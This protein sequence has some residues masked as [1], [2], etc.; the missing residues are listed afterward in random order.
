MLTV[1]LVVFAAFSGLTAH[2]FVWP[3]LP[4]VPQRADAIVQLG[5]PG[6]RRLV[7]MDLYRQGRAPV[8]AI[9]VPEDEARWGWCDRGSVHGVPVVCF[10]SDPFTTRGEARA[11]AELAG[12]YEWHSV[13]LVTTRDQAWRAELRTKRCYDGALSVAI[14]PLPWY[15]WPKQI[16][17]QWAATAKALTFE[18]SC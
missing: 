13:I 14:A 12:K 16:A 17:Y 1:F 5:G 2:L 9:S 15:L 18:K 6:E 8:V 7:A 4:P 11:L 3:D 10:H